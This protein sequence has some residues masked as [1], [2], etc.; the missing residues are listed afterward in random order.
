ML[1]LIQSVYHSYLNSVQPISNNTK[2]RRLLNRGE[3]SRPTGSITAI[4]KSIF[5]KELFGFYKNLLET[6]LKIQEQD[7]L[8][9]IFL[10]PSLLN[11]NISQIKLKSKG[12]KIR[13]MLRMTFEKTIH[14]VTES[15][16]IVSD[17]F[18]L[19]QGLLFNRAEVYQDFIST[20]EPFDIVTDRAS[21]FKL[22]HVII[23]GYYGHAGIYLG[24]KAQLIE[25]GLWDDPIVKP[26]QKEI[27]QG[28][29]ML[30]AKRTGV[31]IRKLS[32]YF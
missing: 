16:G 30:E 12:S 17:T 5:S 11:K 8:K 1:E 2:L 25:R 14:A 10:E 24:T 15:L 9:V 21:K 22:S 32:E 19:R 23:P 29:V 13:D 20:L 28:Y 26:F 3:D 7:H 4:Q 6:T 18:P 31:R 27:E